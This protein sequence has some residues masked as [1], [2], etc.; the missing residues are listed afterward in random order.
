ML[1]PFTDTDGY[2]S[3]GKIP[4]ILCVDDDPEIS[5]TIEL[6]LRSF[7]VR[8]ER[9]FYGTQGLWNAVT[10]RPNLIIMDLAMP[11]GDGQSVL[12][13]LKRNTRTADIPVIVLTGMRDRTLSKR[14]FHSGASQ[15]LRKPIPFD[16]LFHEINRFIDLRERAPD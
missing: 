13:C 2:K 3:P 15:Y 4:L 9:A 1:R 5:R 14:L 12:E 6:R 7:D 11:N 16:D 8:V 10:K